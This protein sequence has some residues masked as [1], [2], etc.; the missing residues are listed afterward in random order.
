MKVHLVAVPF[1]SAKWFIVNVDRFAARHK[2]TRSQVIKQAISEMLSNNIDV[3]NID[4]RET[5]RGDKVL[6]TVKMRDEMLQKL[7]DYAMQHRLTRS[8][9]IRRAVLYYLS[10]HE[11]EDP[12]IRIRV[13]YLRI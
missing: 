2:I 12:P 8:E 10:K 3:T 7:D 11:K 6:C 13:E 5:L 9:T 4:D 1:K